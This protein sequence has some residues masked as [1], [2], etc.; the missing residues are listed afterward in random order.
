MASREQTM[1]TERQEPQ[2]DPLTQWLASGERG[3]SSNAIVEHLTGIRCS[4]YSHAADHPHDPDDLTRCVR[5]LEQCPDLRGR[6]GDM[7]YRS[8]EWAALVGAW[9]ELVEMLDSEVPEWRDR[10]WGSALRTYRRMR[11][12]IEGATP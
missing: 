10:P 8:P 11:E 2:L 3:I 7:A 1:T 4:R 6:L 5:L 12:L 9:D